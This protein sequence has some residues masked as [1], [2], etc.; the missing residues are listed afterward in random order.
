MAFI[1]EAPTL[2]ITGGNPMQVAGKRVSEF[3]RNFIDYIISGN[4]RANLAN[5]WDG[6]LDLAFD[7]SR[8]REMPCK[9]LPN[10]ITKWEQRR[11]TQ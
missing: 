3:I 10:V 11:N 5:S 6:I 2:W 7:E 1:V 8:D 4:R 9:V